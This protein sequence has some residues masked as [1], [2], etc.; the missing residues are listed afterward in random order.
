MKKNLRGV[1]EWTAL[2]P[3]MSPVRTLFSPLSRLHCFILRCQRRPMVP[4][5]QPLRR[6]PMEVV[7]RV[8]A[9][10]EMLLHPIEAYNVHTLAK[11]S[12]KNPGD[13]AEVGVFRGASA[14]LICEAKG[15]RALHLF[16]TFAGLPSPSTLDSRFDSGQFASDF[17]DVKRYLSAY[18]NLMWHKGLF[19]ET[20]TPVQD[21]KFAF[22]HL[23]V[24]LYEG[25]L[26]ALQFFYPRMSP[27]GLIVSHD[28][29]Y[30]EGV[31]AAFD[32]FFVDKPEVVV[33]IGST[34]CLVSKSGG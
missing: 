14:K 3:S 31:Q 16:D 15:N 2:S 29:A 12:L 8:Y 4:F 10:R 33:E 24:D 28:Y 22:V 27:G 21:R 30:A 17:E 1:L 7:E 11:K 19:P 18:P 32:E 9:E 25:T 5:D 6:D 13:F 34:Q 20:A 23:D 26:H